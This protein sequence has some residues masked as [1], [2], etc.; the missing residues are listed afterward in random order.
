MKNLDKLT[1]AE[2]LTI[3]KKQQKSRHNYRQRPEIKAK[4]REYQRRPEIRVKQREYY[5][6]YYRK[7]RAAFLAAKE[8]GLI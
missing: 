6:K 3:L 5:R 4:R 1:K 7:V 8:A 2:L